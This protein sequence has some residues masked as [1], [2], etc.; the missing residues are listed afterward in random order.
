[1]TVSF[2]AAVV[3]PLAPSLLVSGLAT[4]AALD[5]TLGN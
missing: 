5:V 1:M 4:T 3:D 2:Q